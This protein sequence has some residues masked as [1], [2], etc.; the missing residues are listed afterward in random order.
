[1][2]YGPEGKPVR[3]DRLYSEGRY[4]DQS[5][6]SWVSVTWHRVTACVP[7]DMLP[8][9]SEDW[10]YVGGAVKIEVRDVEVQECRYCGELREHG[11]VKPCCPDDRQREREEGFLD[12][13]DVY[14]DMFGVWDE[15]NECWYDGPQTTTTADTQVPLYPTFEHATDRARELT[16]ERLYGLNT[17]V[18]ASGGDVFYVRGAATVFVAAL[19]RR[20]EVF[21]LHTPRGSH[22][23][24]GVAWGPQDDA[25]VDALSHYTAGENIMVQLSDGLMH[26]ITLDYRDPLVK[27][28][29]G[30]EAIL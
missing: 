1:M 30:A 11:F 21:R 9:E 8:P 15:D 12:E 18:S 19:C 29:D 24:V 20:F 13:D 28:A 22:L 7:R 23:V 16:R 3:L 14:E 4:L 27:L 10:E 6:Q 25:V 2:D 5:F 17:F 26:P